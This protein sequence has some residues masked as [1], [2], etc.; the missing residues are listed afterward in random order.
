M[1]LLLCSPRAFY[2]CALVYIAEAL[3]WCRV[4]YKMIAVSQASNMTPDNILL[5]IYILVINKIIIIN[6]IKFQSSPGDMAVVERQRNGMLGHS[7]VR[8]TKSRL[9]GSRVRD[10]VVVHLGLNVSS[11]AHNCG[12]VVDGG[13]TMTAI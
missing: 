11:S 1:D 3:R 2:A 6:N 4:S 8:V 10:H 5:Y 13:G 9:Y 12:C 7:C